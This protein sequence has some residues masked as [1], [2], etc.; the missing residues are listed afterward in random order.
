MKAVVIGAG[1]AGLASALLLRYRGWD[2]TVL[3]KN[4]QPGGRAR[5]WEDRGFRFDMGPSWYLMPEVFERFFDAV[6]TSVGEQYRLTKLE[7][8]YRVYFENQAPVTIGANPE[9]TKRLFDTLEP[10]GGRR[11]AGYLDSAQAKYDAALNK[12]LFR[13]YDSWTALADPELLTRGLKLG[14]LGSLDR[15][16]RRYVTDRRAV[17]LLEYAM[18]FLGTSPRQAPAMYSLLSHVDFNLGVS[19]PEGGMNGVARS[20][21]RLARERGVEFLYDHDVTRLAVQRGRVASIETNRATFEADA[22]LNTGDYVW[23]E[24]QLLE[25]RW[26]TYRR[27]YWSRRVLA[28]SMFVIFLGVNR[29]V[30]LLHHNLYFS[31]DWNAHFD[32]IFKRPSWPENPCFYV[33]AI[34]RTDPSMAPPG[35]EN[36]FILI[37]IAPGLDDTDE[38][39]ARYR[40]LVL[41]QV[42]RRTGT[43]LTGAIVTERVYGPRDFEAD[44][45]AYKGTALGLAHT[46]FQ[47]AL[48]RPS[49]RSR[50][51]GNL[52]YAGQYTHPGVGVPMTLISAQLAVKQL[53]ENQRGI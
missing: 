16:V 15:F 39:R 47:T 6:G 40:D 29:R 21:E 41:T 1:F 37:P 4:D 24:T 38:V 7:P 9:A 5:L 53:V 49:Q 48:F 31:D 18:V 11:L 14:L 20:M 33:S 30:D 27:R 36:L 44:Y 52:W 25:P 45:H 23:G 43:R 3:E 10:G 50:K 42:E 51:V 19:F 13:N 2:V 34:T 8:Q 17:Q 28:P 32:T 46:L 22:V 26:Q 35:C 12:F